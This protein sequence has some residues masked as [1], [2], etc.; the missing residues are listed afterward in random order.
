MFISLIHVGNTT[1]EK[2]HFALLIPGP[3]LILRVLLK[4]VR[5]Q[6]CFPLGHI[7]KE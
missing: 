6:L 1:P 2:L 7:L 3:Q 5:D 4:Q